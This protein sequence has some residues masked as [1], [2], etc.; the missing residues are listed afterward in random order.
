MSGMKA[1]H[2]WPPDDLERIAGKNDLKVAPFRD[3]G[4]TYGTPTWV[5]NVAVEGDLYV[6]A[7]HGE[8]SSWYQAALKQKAGRIHAAGMV[9]EVTFERVKGA[10]NNLID[11][12]YQ[13]KYKKSKYL[14]S[15]ISDKA[16]KA[17]IR[18]VPF[19]NSS[20]IRPMG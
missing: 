2:K 10:V 7:Y 17:T 15:M 11:K 5:W 6:R 13:V 9:K 8:K 19:V 12:A 20:G 4:A 18:I 1:I 16:R 14:K 3:D